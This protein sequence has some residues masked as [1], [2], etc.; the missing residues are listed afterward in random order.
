M[1]GL[2]APMAAL[3]AVLLGSVC[4]PFSASADGVGT[5]RILIVGDSVTQG[6]VGDFTWRYRLWKT[7]QAEAKDVDFVGYR[8]GEY[9]S[10]GTP[11]DRSDDVLDDASQ[12]A[13]PNFDQD[14]AARWG[15][16]LGDIE[17]PIH[18]TMLAYHPDVVLNDLGINDLTWG[19]STPQELISRMGQFVADVRAVN[20]QATVVI[21]QLTQTWA[22]YPGTDE[23]A[24]VTEYN[25]LLV[26]L[27]NRLD[28]KD[29]RVIAA[30]RPSD[31]VRGVDTYDPAHP[32]ESG[33]VKIAKQFS[34]VLDS[35][36]IPTTPLPPP[37]PPATYS[38]AAHLRAAAR[39]H[40][41]RL[42]FDTP[43]GATRQVIWRRDATRHGS[44]RRVAVVGPDTHRFR[45]HP[46]RSH[47]RYAFR[48]RAWKATQVSTVYSN[49]VRV[50][51]R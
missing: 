51:V 44:W 37:T 31:Y 33:E 1:R 48:L 38:G 47:H 41:V 45:V 23:S 18:D 6:R 3:V 16:S 34:D 49:R 24:R 9:D 50:R 28:R 17:V 43:P 40:A 21:G 27:A 12:Y 11:W 25:D 15:M 10:N 19:R 26:D 29:S 32:S 14:H 22:T 39:H 7:L 35:L 46:L 8:R 2:F 13:D 30:L 42:V 36:P 20:P 5:S 4:L